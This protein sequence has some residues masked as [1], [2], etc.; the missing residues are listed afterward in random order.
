MKEIK[1]VECPM[2]R[3]LMVDLRGDD[4]FVNH[5]PPRDSSNPST[6]GGDS[7]HGDSSSTGPTHSG[8]ERGEEK[9]KREPKT[10]KSHN[11][12]KNVNFPN[13]K[14]SKVKRKVYWGTGDPY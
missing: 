1:Y 13:K 6:S 2:C 3:Q 8:V 14:E 9:Q 10:I 5:N 7:L 11:A 4:R 12:N